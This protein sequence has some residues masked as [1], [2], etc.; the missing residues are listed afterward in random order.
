[1]KLLLYFLAPVLA[2]LTASAAAQQVEGRPLDADT[3]A[4]G[5]D[6]PG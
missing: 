2:L 6:S 5:R 3:D 4:C 1:M